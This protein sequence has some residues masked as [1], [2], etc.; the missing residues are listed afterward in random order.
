MR[1]TRRR[2]RRRN[3]GRASKLDYTHLLRKASPKGKSLLR[4]F[5]GVRKPPTI[6]TLGGKL[7]GVGSNATLVGL[8]QSPAITIA[9]GPMKRHSK[10]VRRKHHGQLVT[11][12]HGRRLFILNGRPPGGR[13]KFLGY[14]PTTEYIPYPGVEA[15]GSF[16]K[17]K[18]WVH[19]HNDSNG[20]WPKVY[21][22]RNG[23]YVYA[24]GSYKVG[25]WLYR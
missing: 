23:N 19:S 5:W 6:K 1:R 12:S 2:H 8:G 16:K 3:R 22:D 14:V 25:K 10:I 7:P 24:R 17:G 4:K 21:V 13:L 20:R 18:H 15:M 9:D 11:D